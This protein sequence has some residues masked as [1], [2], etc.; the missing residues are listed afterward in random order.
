MCP[1]CVTLTES[2]SESQTPMPSSAESPD[3]GLSH[4]PDLCQVIKHFCMYGTALCYLWRLPIARQREVHIDWRTQEHA[5]TLGALG[6]FGPSLRKI[7]L[8][9][10]VDKGV[11]GLIKERLL[12]WSYD[13]FLFMWMFNRRTLENNNGNQPPVLPISSSWLAFHS[14]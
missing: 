14:N 9:P 13:H 4:L 5:Q 7:N 6:S 3:E 1:D 8:F 10:S 11:C 12:N 2:C